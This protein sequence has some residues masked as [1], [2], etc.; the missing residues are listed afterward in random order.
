MEGARHRTDPT[1][2]GTAPSPSPPT[3]R[4]WTSAP[5]GSTQRSDHWHS[6][7]GPDAPFGSNESLDLW[8]ATTPTAA[9]PINHGPGQRADSPS[10]SSSHRPAPPPQGERR[11]IARRGRHPSDRAGPWPSPGSSDTPA[12]PSDQASAAEGSGAGRP[13]LPQEPNDGV[14]ATPGTPRQDPAP[15]SHRSG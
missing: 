9:M 2:D 14:A 7:A 1:A 3:N 11:R 8:T 5:R 15:S 10:D 6:P 13:G 12:E 4:C